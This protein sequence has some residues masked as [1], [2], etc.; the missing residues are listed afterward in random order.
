MSIELPGGLYHYKEKIL[1]LSDNELERFC[2]LLNV[3][4]RK[5]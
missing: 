2:E 3:L 1:N 4:R 5:K